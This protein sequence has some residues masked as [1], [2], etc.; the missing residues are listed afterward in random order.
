MTDNYVYHLRLLLSH[1]NKK[2]SR[3]VYCHWSPEFRRIARY[4]AVSEILNIGVVV[5][6]QSESFVFS[7]LVAR[8]LRDGHLWGVLKR[9]QRQ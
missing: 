9:L 2:V 5:K 1:V 3:K 8:L 4:S 7:G 6:N